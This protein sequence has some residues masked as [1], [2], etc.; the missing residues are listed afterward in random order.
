MELN[1]VPAALLA[2][3]S[4]GAAQAQEPTNWRGFYVGGN[5]GGAWSTT[6][7]TW[8]AYGP[9][10]NTAVF[11]TRDCPNN[12]AFVGGVQLGYNFQYAQWVWGLG[13]D[14][15]FW[16]SSTHNRSLTYTGPIFPDGTYALS[17]KVKPNGFAIVGP[18]VGYAVGDWLPYIRAGGVFTSGTHD[19]AASYTPIGAAAPTAAFDGGKNS[20]SNGWGV[21]AGLEYAMADQWSVGAQYTYVNLGKGSN[22]VNYCSTTGIVNGC[23]VFINGGYSLDS[24]HNSF[25]ASVFRVQINY[26]FGDPAHAAAVVAAAL[27]RPPPPRPPPPPPPPPPP[28]PAL[29]PDTPPGVKADANGCPCD[30]TQEVHFAT[31]SAELTDQDKALLDKMIVNL[32]RLHFVSGEID[33]FTDS[34]GTAEYNKGLSERR[35]QAVADYLQSHG[36][37]NGR[38]TAKGYGEDNPVANNATAEGRAHNRRVVLHR[39]D[40]GR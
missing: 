25:T 11:N 29:C 1:I 22:S 21:G 40:C 27:P 14:Y 38:M 9:L 24:I 7:N 17:G 13:A 31:N 26:R 10:A 2:L 15:D 16:S 6:C 4:I 28:K 35:A 8:A 19:I 32:T 3:A 37:S 30:V 34:T 20:R 18:R 5:L 23:N 39:T 36:I 33:G 12:G